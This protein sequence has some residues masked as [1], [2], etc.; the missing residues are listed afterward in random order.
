MRNT[1]TFPYR[2]SRISTILT[3]AVLAVLP[4]PLWAQEPT[5]APATQPALTTSAA[6]T[7]PAGATT[8]VQVKK[9]G[10][11]ALVQGRSTILTAPWPV[12]RV[13]LTDPKVAD[14]QVLSPTQILVQSKAAGGTDVF[15]WNQ[16][17]EVLQHHLE[18]SI[19][20]EALKTELKRIFPAS[21]LE[22]HQTRGL[23]TV[24][25]TF[26]RA[27][28]AEQLHRYF[29][30]RSLNLLDL[31][32]MAGIQQVQ[33]K[34]V[35]AEAS[36]SAMRSLGINAVVA[37]SSAFGGSVIGPENSGP[38]NPISIGAPAGSGVGSQNMQ[39]LNSSAVSSAV[40][41]FGGVPGADLQVF[42]AALAENQFMRILAEP[43]LVALSG[44]EA[45]FLAGGEYPIPVVQ[46]AGASVSGTS[47]T[48]EYKEFGVRLRFR[49][50]VLGDG[51][52][53][54]QV[55]PEVSQLST[56]PGSV[57]IQGFSIP[58]LL[59]RRTETTLE[60]ASGQTFGM[61]GLI[62]QTVEA[63]NSRIPGLGDVP[64]LGALFRSVRYRTGDTELIVLITA[65][66]VEP[67]NQVNSPPLP[68][69]LHVA[70]NDW[71]LFVLGKIEGKVPPKLA[72]VDAQYL[73]ESGL[74]QLKGPG[75]WAVY[76]SVSAKSQ[77]P[78]HTQTAPAHS[79]N[80]SS[81]L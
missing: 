46:G 23:V 5:T 41:M 71:E 54:L 3:W 77:A 26:T 73:R 31:T 79:D 74:N 80:V 59:T 4:T 32:T 51:N 38:I 55:A 25:G 48:I 2:G 20:N 43:S 64:I 28:Q 37:G 15:L 19:D 18:V 68:G 81:G 72:P 44:H 66:L 16:D 57:Q 9:N 22:A 70:P 62:N 47:I 49:P 1:G 36:R 7:Q 69:L 45:T 61:A 12:K 60:L 65:N 35:V 34:V 21:N 24:T 33:I 6:T 13:S 63:R 76:D 52:I 50:T 14:V 29:T 53:R 17:E 58:S 27:E 11:L 67:L 56:G 8:Q 78:L 10:D 39:F 40:T 75:A 30:A 42:I